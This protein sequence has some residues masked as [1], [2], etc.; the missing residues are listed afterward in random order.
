[1]KLRATAHR[2]INIQTATQAGFKDDGNVKTFSFLH[3]YSYL[4]CSNLPVTCLYRNGLMAPKKVS[5]PFYFDF[6]LLGQE[7][8]MLIK[9]M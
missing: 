2:F 5:S 9:T 3:C 1:M 8:A 6:R 7:E 4:A